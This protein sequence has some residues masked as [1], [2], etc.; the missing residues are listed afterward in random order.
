MTVHLPHG[1]EQLPR[2]IHL[3]KWFLVYFLFLGVLFV[4]AYFLWE[5]Q[6]KDF[7]QAW[8]RLGHFSF[9][10]NGFFGKIRE[11]FDQ[12]KAQMGDLIRTAGPELMFVLL[13]IYL[14]VATTFFPVPTNAM[15]AAAAA[16]GSGSMLLA[17]G[18][19]LL[20]ATAST[21]ANL[22]DFHIYV[23]LLRSRKIAKIRNTRLY[24]WAAKWFAKRP[25]WIMTIV[26]IL[27][28]PADVPLR[29]LCA[30]YGYSRILFAASNF[31]GRLLRY[32]VI[33][34]VILMMPPRY[35]WM[36]PLVLLGLAVVVGTIK[37]IPAMCR[38]LRRK[39]VQSVEITLPARKERI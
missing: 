28:M 15:I 27:P 29:I 8:D 21:I 33:V 34:L 24:H 14:S 37:L 22:T 23:W 20:G 35:R 9:N 30:V 31:I 38:R 17:M 39:E 7:Q 19:C 13:M 10:A 1:D 5:G 3:A 25:F 16:M 4:L 36:A 11:L 2:H 6:S 26:N 32:L 12:A 18:I